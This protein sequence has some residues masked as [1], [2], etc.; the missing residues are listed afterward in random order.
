MRFNELG[1]HESTELAL[2]A[3]G[4]EEATPVQEQTLPVLLEGRDIIAQAQTGTGKTAAFGIAL[5][6]ACRKGR[7]GIVL[8]PTREL[9]KQVQR[10]L[11]AI[12]H[13]SKVD[14]VCLIGGASFGDQVRAI[15]RHPDAI[16]VA[17]PGRVVDHLDRGT[18][19]LK[20]MSI[21]VLDEADEMLSMG[22]QEEVDRI[23]SALP[24]E[25]QG[26]L[27]SATLPPAIEKLAKRAL[28]TP[29]TIKTGSGGAAKSVA[30]AY[31]VVPHRHKV[32]A[33]QRIVEFEQP[34]ATLLFC[35]TRA[36]V[37]DL[38]KQLDA[39]GAEALHGGMSQ[40]QRDQAMERFRT[41]RSTLLVA[42]DV[43]ARGIDVE[44]IELVLHDEPPA[45]HET[46]IHRIG[47]TGRA[48]R[49][50]SSLMF[51]T[52]NKIRT[53][54]GIERATGKLIH[55]ELPSDQELEE[56]RSFRTIETLQAIEPSDA[57]R[58]SFAQAIE[59]GLSAEDIAVRALEWLSFNES[60]AQSSA[61]EPDPSE[62]GALAL[63]VGKMDRVMAGDI[64]G[65]LI[66]EGGLA[67]DDIGRIDLLD[68]MSVVEVP[69]KE[70][71]RL[72]QVLGGSS[73]RSRR[74]LPRE[75]EGW[76]FRTERR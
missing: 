2:E 17:T 62:P 4:F 58:T 55:Y 3:M 63:K 11:Q 35:R 51:L 44:E 45:D 5:I 59:A 68:K 30:Q 53:L 57:A 37:E 10:E 47:R 18:L 29:Q 33:I 6:E 50:G 75:A 19:D 48:G 36:R 24:A 46:Y 72:C 22:F 14:V 40:P 69:R 7:R 15:N 70:L 8:T 65:M 26:M 1:L 20:T 41:G 27:F 31:A 38:T 54:Q 61:A 60:Q 64:V 23:I 67:R 76:G 74:V 66:N 56:A 12:A 25:R 28:K 21:L 9:A 52:P 73:L 34:T 42:T 43:A 49:D 13:G 71:Q 32:D 39:L 16:F